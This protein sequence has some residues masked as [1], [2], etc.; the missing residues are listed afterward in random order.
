MQLLA[1]DVFVLVKLALNVGE[2]PPMASLGAQLGLSPSR[3][4][5]AIKRA[6]AARLL[7]EHGDQVRLPNLQEFL[8]HGFKYAF[9]A[10]R[11]ELTRG[12]PTS[13]AAPPLNAVITQP[14][15][16]P[17]VWPYAQGSVR[18]VTLLPLHKNVPAAA[19]RDQP[20][21]EMLALLDALRDGRARERAIAEQEIQ[22]R[23]G[24]R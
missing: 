11:G 6:K 1:Q 17:P 13:Y 16:P 4:H 22:R 5:D 24:A 21:Y 18:G 2:R 14:D 10:Q 19:L 8:I 7:S 9:P 15:E 3:I 23:L 12:V 20:L